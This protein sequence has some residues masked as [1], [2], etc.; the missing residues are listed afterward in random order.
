MPNL[1][2][3]AHRF[4]D[5]WHSMMLRL[6]GWNWWV[7]VI[8]AIV[9]TS[10]VIGVEH[11]WG[12]QVEDLL[13]RVAEWGKATAGKPMGY[14]V[15]ALLVFVGGWMAFLVGAAWLETSPMGKAI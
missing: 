5:W 1:E 15:L 2:N 10:L 7:W 13:L 3:L 11:W 8:V 14:G 12:G 9:L 4:S 6:K